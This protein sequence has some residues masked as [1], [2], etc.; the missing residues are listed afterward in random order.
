MTIHAYQETYLYKAQSALGD[1]FVC[2]SFSLVE[3]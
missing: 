1:A 3:S 2:G